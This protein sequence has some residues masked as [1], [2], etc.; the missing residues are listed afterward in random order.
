MAVARVFGTIARASLL[1]ARLKRLL[2]LEKELLRLHVVAEAELH[3]R[4][5]G[6]AKRDQ[7]Q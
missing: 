6:E 1:E 3:A 7:R 2:D 4:A 5:A